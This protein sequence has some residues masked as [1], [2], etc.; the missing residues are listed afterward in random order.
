MNKF[1]WNWKYH[2]WWQ[3]KNFILRRKYGVVEPR[4]IPKYE[5]ID[6]D[7]LMAEA[8]LECVAQY[9][10]HEMSDRTFWAEYWDKTTEEITDEDL[11]KNGYERHRD[12]FIIYVKK[13]KQD[14]E[15]IMKIYEYYKSVHGTPEQELDFLKKY[16]YVGDDMTCQEICDYVD[17]DDLEDEILQLV[18]SIRGY[19]WS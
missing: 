8:M 18:L 14:Y 10:E 13:Q 12:E 17:G 15:T 7:G 3:I 5:W 2:Y 1:W 6:R 9:V 4:Y 11:V 19:L 16:G